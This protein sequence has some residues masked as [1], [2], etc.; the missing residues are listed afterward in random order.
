MC[1]NAFQR[2]YQ[3]I[4]G[5][6]TKDEKSVEV[7]QKVAADKYGKP[8]EEFNKDQFLDCD[9]HCNERE[10]KLDEGITDENSR[11]AVRYSVQLLNDVCYKCIDVVTPSYRGLQSCLENRLE[12]EEDWE[13]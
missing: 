1:I 4:T 3:C 5:T 12:E 11:K 10:I 6:D 9:N 7:C 13:S 8:T 2:F